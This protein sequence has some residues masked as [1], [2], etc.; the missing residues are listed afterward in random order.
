MITI[1]GL[2]KAGAEE[3]RYIGR[4]AK[5]L[6]LRLDRHLYNAKRGYPR[7]ISQWIKRAKSVEI[8]PLAQCYEQCAAAVERAMVEQYWSDGHRLTN[9][10]LVPRTRAPKGAVA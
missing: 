9:S 7:S 5:P 4:S 2:R 6:D 8:V 3:I 10:H 1:Y